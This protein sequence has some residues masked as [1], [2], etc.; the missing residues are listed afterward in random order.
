[1]DTGIAGRQ[2]QTIPQTIVTGAH[3]GGNQGVSL[4]PAF[5]RDDMEVCKALQWLIDLRIDLLDQSQCRFLCPKLLDKTCKCF[6]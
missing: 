2:D 1:M 5:G 6:P 4:L 3:I